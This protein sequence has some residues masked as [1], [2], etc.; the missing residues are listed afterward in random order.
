MK[1]TLQ[2]VFVSMLGLVLLGGCKKSEPSGTASAPEPAAA[3]AAAEKA[4]AQDFTLTDQDGTAHTL[5]GFRGKIVVL[6]WLNPDCPFVKRHHETKTTMADLAKA[7]A[8]KGVVWLGINT[9]HYFDTAKNKEFVTRLNLPYAVL[10]DSDGSVGKRYGAARTPEMVVID[11]DGN[12]AYHGAIDDDPKGEKSA[13]LNYVK[14]ALDELLA[15]KPVSVPHTDPY[16]CSV[17]YAQ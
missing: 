7:Y 15:G 17:K 3:P 12:I 4:P 1:R 11:K 2:V 5:S 9:T 16:G 6:E 10:N 8:D 14:Q 13:P